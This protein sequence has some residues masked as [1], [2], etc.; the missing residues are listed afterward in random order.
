MYIERKTYTIALL[1]F[2]WF[3]VQTMALHHEFSAEHLSSANHSCICQAVH[4]DDLDSSTHS[5]LLIALKIELS[6]P[7]SSLCRFDSQASYT[8]HSPRAPPIAIS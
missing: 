8:S 2:G 1:L 3:S 7:I 4:L 5:E 6:N